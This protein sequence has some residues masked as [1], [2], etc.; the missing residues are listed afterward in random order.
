MLNHPSSWTHRQY[1]R[2]DQLSLSV[3]HEHGGPNSDEDHDERGSSSGVL[4]HHEASSRHR[5]REFE[6]LC[7]RRYRVDD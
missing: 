7:H 3:V 1:D 4:D 6:S 2:D 5:W